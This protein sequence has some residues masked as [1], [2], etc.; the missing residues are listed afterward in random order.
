M[1]EILAVLIA[2]IA[3]LWDLKTT[4][5]PDDIPYLMTVVGL[6]YWFV[7]GA[8]TGNMQP[9]ITS[10]LMGTAVLFVGLVLYAKGKWGGADAWILAAIFYMVPVYSGEI[11]LAG[12]IV[13][14]FIVSLVYMVAY[15]II[16]GVKHKVFGAF[17]AELRNNSG[18]VVAVPLAFLIF[19]IFLIYAGVMTL[20]TPVLMFSFILAMMLFWVYAKVIEKNVFVR[21]I[22]TNQLKPGDVLQETRWIGVTEKEIEQFRLK[23]KYVTIKDGVRFVPVFSITLAVTLVWGNL[24][25]LIL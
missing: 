21:K 16:L 9:F 15:T 20:L 10:L 8:S 18:F 25:F 12:Y 2:G 19:S 5:V 1:I 22:K 11:I 7:A 23:Q 6:T 14:F 24:L 4:E 17:A 3:G 13:N